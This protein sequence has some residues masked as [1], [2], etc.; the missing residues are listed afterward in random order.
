MGTTMLC[1][2]S[3]CGSTP[4]FHIY[5]KLC[6]ALAPSTPLGAGTRYQNKIAQMRIFQQVGVRVPQSWI[7][8]DVGQLN[9]PE[10]RAGRAERPV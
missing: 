1:A 3:S 6:S 9:E 4:P 2:P 8:E 5:H 7:L 10:A